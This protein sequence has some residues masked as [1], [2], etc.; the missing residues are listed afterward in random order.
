METG[1]RPDPFSLAQLNPE[2]QRIA[3]APITENI[4]VIAGP[5]TGKTFTLVYRVIS[6]LERGVS[7]QD[8][9]VLTFTNKAISSFRSKLKD[10]V[11]PKVAKSVA[12]NTFHSYCQT[13]LY[14]HG[15]LVGLDSGWTVSDSRE[16][17]FMFQQAAHSIFS[18]KLTLAN[19]RKLANELRTLKLRR[20]LTGYKEHVLD[21]EKRRVYEQY[22]LIRAKSSI[23]DYDDLLVRAKELLEHQAKSDQSDSADQFAK[24]K[25]ILVDEFQDSIPLQWVIIKLLLRISKECSLT[26]V[27]DPDQT[28]YGFAGSDPTLFQLMKKELANVNVVHLKTNYRA[29]QQIADT[30]KALLGPHRT[31]FASAFMPG[32]RPVFKRLPSANAQYNWVAQEIKT[33]MEFDPSL[34]PNDFA[35]LFRAGYNCDAQEAALK[36]L[37]FE[38]A[39]VRNITIFD[40][41]RIVELVTLLKFLNN[42][43][44]DMYVLYLLRHPWPI[45]SA[46]DC[47][48]AMTHATVTDTPLWSSL[49]TPEEWIST[50]R[51]QKK[52]EEFVRIVSHAGQIISE[53]NT[54]EGIISALNYFVEQVSTK[55]APK[56]KYHTKYQEDQK[57]LEELYSFIRSSTDA[58]TEDASALQ[59]FLNSYTHYQA[60]PTENQIVVSTVHA[61]KGL[62]WKTVFVADLDDSSYPHL[63]AQFTRDPKDIEEERRVLY[64]AATRAKRNLYCVFSPK[65]IASQNRVFDRS[66]FLTDGLLKKYF[67]RPVEEISPQLAQW[68]RV[69]QSY[70]RLFSPINKRITQHSIRAMHTLR[71]IVR[72]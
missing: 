22:D 10:A 68:N 9:L 19:R 52:L 5:G 26:V 28:I 20:A 62:E 25:V 53:T 58:M 51:S 66:R 48:F 18:K 71:S 49:Q 31:D 59:S 27:G 61:A 14:N 67:I 39:I 16:A 42:K 57:L 37:G 24:Y 69:K 54:G 8:I 13:L 70:P 65:F 43:S 29:T 38:V 41:P 11:G 40:Q 45:I 4:Q 46:K 72:A 50:S 32:L 63:R 2:Q 6:L 3:D 7:P 55:I 23:L 64:V 34:K 15:Y 36:T 60:T 33:L 1:S 35:V 12:I 56:S 47:D 30:T 44:Q 21:D 17:D